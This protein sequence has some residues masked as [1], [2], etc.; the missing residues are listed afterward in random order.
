MYS[1]PQ[2]GRERVLSFRR[3]LVGIDGR[4]RI[5]SGLKLDILVENTDALLILDCDSVLQLVIVLNPDYLTG[6]PG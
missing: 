5:G 1:R 3:I 4:K 6:G 2:L